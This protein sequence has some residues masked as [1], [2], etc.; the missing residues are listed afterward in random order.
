MKMRVEQMGK[1]N[2]KLI[3]NMAR[4]YERN[5]DTGEIKSRAKGDYGNERIEE[6]AMSDKYIGGSLKKDVIHNIWGTKRIVFQD[7]WYVQLS[8]VVNIIEKKL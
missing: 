8:E 6:P 4:I 7:N 5:S 3:N 1:Q 2:D